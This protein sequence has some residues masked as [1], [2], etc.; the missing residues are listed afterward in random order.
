MVHTC[1]LR[2][3][4]VSVDS[5]YLVMSFL[6]ENLLKKDNKEEKKSEEVV[7]VVAEEV[8]NEPPTRTGGKKLQLHYFKRILNA[9]FNSLDRR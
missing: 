6:I 2:G 5:L 1:L 7:V 4:C 8:K 9:T 3:C